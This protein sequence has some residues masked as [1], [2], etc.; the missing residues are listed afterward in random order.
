MNEGKER[1]PGESEEQTA[2]SRWAA[3]MRQV[4]WPEPRFDYHVRGGYRAVARRGWD[5]ARRE[6]E[7]CLGGRVV[8]G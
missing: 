2:L 7:D 6:I 3:L 4:R 1:T 5:E 8:Y